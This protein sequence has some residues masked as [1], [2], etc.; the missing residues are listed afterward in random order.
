MHLGAV[1]RKCAT[2]LAAVEARGL[3][4][5]SPVLTPGRDYLFFEKVDCTQQSLITTMT[6]GAVVLTPNLIVIIPKESTGSLVVAAINTQYDGDALRFVKALLDD[7]AV[8]VAKLE[9]ALGS[10]YAGS[11]QRWV[12]PLAE[13][14]TLKATTGFFGMISLKMPR[15]SVRRLVIRDKGGK[16]AAKA[17]L[18]ARPRERAAS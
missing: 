15:E 1:A 3:L 17:F 11:P 12:F 4:S 14:E 8:D 13:L 7:P 18:D 9:N 6:R 5:M 10:M 16:A 2:V